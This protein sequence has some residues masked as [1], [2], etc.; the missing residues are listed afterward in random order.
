MFANGLKYKGAWKHDKADGDGSC[1]YPS[2]DE[3]TGEWKNDHRCARIV[4][5]LVWGEMQSLTNH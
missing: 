3:Y 4:C 1:V 5:H 2:G